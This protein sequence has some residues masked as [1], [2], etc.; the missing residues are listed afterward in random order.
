MEAF[1][2]LIENYIL[3]LILAFVVRSFLKVLVNRYTSKFVEFSLENYLVKI[4]SNS[5]KASSHVDLFKMEEQ[6]YDGAYNILTP[7]SGKNV[8]VLASMA[9]RLNLTAD[10]PTFS[11]KVLVS[12][13]KLLNILEKFMPYVLFFCVLF[14]TAFFTKAFLFS[15]E[16]FMYCIVFLSLIVCLVTVNAVENSFHLIKKDYQLQPKELSQIRKAILLVHGTVFFRSI[17]IFWKMTDVVKWLFKN[18]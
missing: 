1:L 8:L 15:V 6:K 17:G 5:E 7:P 14:I 4:S 3:Y 2:D 12:Y 18:D 13:L 9:Y 16:L 10:N 11:G